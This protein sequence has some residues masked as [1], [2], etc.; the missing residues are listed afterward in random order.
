MWLVLRVYLKC[1]TSSFD[2]NDDLELVCTECGE[3][4]DIDDLTDMVV[5]E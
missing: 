2:K 4:Y 1:L 3:H 5:E